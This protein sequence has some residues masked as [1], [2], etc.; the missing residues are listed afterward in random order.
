MMKEKVLYGYTGLFDSPDEIIEAA[1]KVAEKMNGNTISWLQKL[2]SKNNFAI[3]GSLIIEE[4][5][6]I[7]IASIKAEVIVPFALLLNT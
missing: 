1:E 2:A 6:K 5:N 7:I 3:A 4:N